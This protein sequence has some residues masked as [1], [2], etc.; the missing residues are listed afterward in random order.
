MYLQNH[1]NLNYIIFFYNFISLILNWRLKKRK[2]KTPYHYFL[3][4]DSSVVLH[5]KKNSSYNLHRV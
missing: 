1:V 4:A 3:I 5:V 2:K